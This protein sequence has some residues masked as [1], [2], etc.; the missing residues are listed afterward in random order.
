MGIYIVAHSNIQN[1]LS[2]SIT[3]DLAKTRQ[4]QI[5]I[6]KNYCKNKIENNNHFHTKPYIM[7]IAI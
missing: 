5:F 4:K 2:T 1:I 6:A 3:F 7:F